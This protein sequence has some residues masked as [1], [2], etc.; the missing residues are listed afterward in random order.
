M[1]L[2]QI[3]FRIAEDFMK[4]SRKLKNTTFCTDDGDPLFQL[5]SDSE[6]A[7]NSYVYQMGLVKINQMQKK[8]AILLEVD[9]KGTKQ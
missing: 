5:P 1:A 6:N 8:V 7:W 2:K 4:T 9:E 3:S